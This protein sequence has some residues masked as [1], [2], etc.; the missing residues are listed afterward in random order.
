VLIVGFVVAGTTTEKVLVRGIGRGLEKFG[1]SGVLASPQL[2]LFAGDGSVLAT[3]AGW[4]G[5]ANLA[6]V[7]AQVG[8]FALD[9]AS[10]DCA[11]VATLPPG[12]YTV[13]ISGANG[14]TGVALAEVY[15]VK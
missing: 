12:A 14:S 7:F 3:N 1:V 6:A 2:R 15:E 10:T 11:L 13:Q 8:A 4:G 9:A 5:E